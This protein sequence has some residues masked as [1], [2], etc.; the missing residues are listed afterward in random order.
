M[1]SDKVIKEIK[2]W[3]KSIITVV[4]L[5]MAIRILIFEPMKIPTGSMEPTLHGIIVRCSVCDTI[6]GGNVYT[7]FGKRC[8]NDRGRLRVIQVGDRILVLKF[9]YGAR[10][11]LTPWRLPGFRR[12]ERGDI[13]VF[14]SPIAPRLNYVKRLVAVGGET[15]EIVNGK[16]HINGKPVEN[17]RFR[18]RYYYNRGDYGKEGVAISVPADQF[19][20]LGDNSAESYD[21]RMWGFV[22][23]KN[24]VG[25]AVFIIW[26]PNRIGVIR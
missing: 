21:S 1:T 6:F 12:P 4:V 22:P 9:V 2:E 19:F 8:P 7:Q 3:V 26:P 23:M 14:R 18:A 24:L 11:P 15:V 13:I 25:K 17:E 20:A 10:I 5:A 16:I